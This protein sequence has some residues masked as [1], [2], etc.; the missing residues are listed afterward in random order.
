MFEIRGRPSTAPVA[1]VLQEDI[2]RTIREDDGRL[3]ELG[4]R[5]LRFPTAHDRRRRLFVPGPAKVCPATEE[6]SERQQAVPKEYTTLDEVRQSVE[7]IAAP[8]KTAICHCAGRDGCKSKRQDDA[9]KDIIHCIENAENAVRDQ[10]RYM[11]GQE[12]IHGFDMEPST[13]SGGPCG[14][15]ILGLLETVVIG[16]RFVGRRSRAVDGRR[17]S[18]GPLPTISGPPVLAQS[19]SMVVMSHVVGGHWQERFP[20]TRGCI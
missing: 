9:V 17:V 4:S 16:R 1:Q 7:N 18:L 8:H 13:R 10:T 5:H 6:P 14:Q 11:F 20:L 2:G 15:V 3:G 12:A 19:G